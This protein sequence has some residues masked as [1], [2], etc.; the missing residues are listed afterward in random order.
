[1]HH[2]SKVAIGYNR[3]A[4]YYSRAGNG[5]YM[6]KWLVYMYVCT[7]VKGR[8][9]HGHS[10]VMRG[11]WRSIFATRAITSVSHGGRSQSKEFFSLHNIRPRVQSRKA[12]NTKDILRSSSRHFLF[13]SPRISFSIWIALRDRM[14]VDKQEEKTTGAD[15]VDTSHDHDS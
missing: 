6:D 10:R 5:R 12:I 15:G 4:C 1:M 3:N 14:D 13:L 2:H 9:A 11:V 8:D 7:K